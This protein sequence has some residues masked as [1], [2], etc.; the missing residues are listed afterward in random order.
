[1]SILLKVTNL[2]TEISNEQQELLIGG[3]VI[4]TPAAP[5]IPPVTLAPVT[6]FL[7]GDYG[8]NFGN[9]SPIDHGST[10]YNKSTSKRNGQHNELAGTFQTGNTF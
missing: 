6:P 10:T 7:W 3:Q 9:S 8:Y 4:P 5:V 1:M 2:L